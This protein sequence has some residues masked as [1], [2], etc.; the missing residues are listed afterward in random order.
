MLRETLNLALKEALKNRDMVA[1]S[2]IRLILAALKDRDIAARGKGEQAL[3]DQSIYAMMQSMVKQRH[4]SM[5]L[6]Q[7]AGR[8]ELVEQEQLE[9]KVIEQFLPAQ[10]DDDAITQAVDE[11]FTIVNPNGM[12]EMGKVMAH[13]RDQYV[14]QMDFKIASGKVK[15][16]FST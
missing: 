10:M 7:Q 2:T 1:S 14:G 9:I 8:E 3:D 6:Y 16:K 11:A 5:A 13:L 12:K 15:Q 4:E